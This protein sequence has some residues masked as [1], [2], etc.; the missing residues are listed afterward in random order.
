[1]AEFWIPRGK[2]KF[3]F[4]GLSSSDEL[5]ES[6]W[7]HVGKHVFYDFFAIFQNSG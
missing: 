3:F 4:L 7:G 5:E 2:H 6:Q 1:M